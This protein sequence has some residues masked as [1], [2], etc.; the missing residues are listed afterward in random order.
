[1][2]WI[3]LIITAV[4][5]IAFAVYCMV[6][7][8]NHQNLRNWLR[9]GVFTVFIIAVLV[10]VIKWSFRWYLLAALLLVLAVIGGISLI[11]KRKDGKPYKPAVIILK[12][13]AVCIITAFTLVPALIFPQYREPKITGTYKVDTA[14]YTY[15]DKARTETFSNTG[16]NRKVNVEFWYPEGTTG[17]CPLVVF[18]HGAFGVKSS[19]TSTYMELASNGYVVCSIDHPYHSFFTSATDGTVTTVNPAYLQQIIDVNSDVYDDE[20]AFKL[21]QDWMNVR[22]GDM[23]FVLD[24][25]LNNAKN[26]SA[27]EVYKLIDT[28]HIGL[29][30][31]SLGG[32]ASAQ[33]GRERKDIAAVVNLDG[34]LLG[35]YEGFKNGKIVFND[36]PYPLPILTIYSDTM[37][38]AMDRVKQKGILDAGT[39]L[40]ATAPYAFTVS[41]KGTNHMSLTDLPLFSP[42][43]T[44]MICSSVHIGGGKEADKYYVIETM[45]RVVLDFFNCYLKDSG[46][47][48]D[49]GSY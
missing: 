32:A 12:G 23:N 43:L 45:N 21:E 35:E 7:K 20:T 1:M 22:T 24:T 5:E 40:A 30:G 14:V 37:T 17:T 3:I 34:D 39:N 10:S 9:V 36:Q 25:I 11:I 29:M 4:I 18:S 19:N 13:A 2:A 49:E 44:N 33:I 38:Q 27:E 8:S 6:T 15:V 47:F 42:L 31:H 28:K 16:E 48:N 41:I 46:A 26:S